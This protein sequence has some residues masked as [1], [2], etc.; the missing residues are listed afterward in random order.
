MIYILR[1]EGI[2]V[3]HIPV[4]LSWLWIWLVYAFHFH[5]WLYLFD[6]HL[7][8]LPSYKLFPSIETMVYDQKIGEKWSRALRWWDNLKR[9]GLPSQTTMKIL[10]TLPLKGETKNWMD[11]SWCTMLHKGEGETRVRKYHE[12]SCNFECGISSVGH[13]FTWSL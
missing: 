7:Y 4:I 3:S 13:S 1:G 5:G 6:L 11:S 2:D 12:N 8:Y 9:M 10:F